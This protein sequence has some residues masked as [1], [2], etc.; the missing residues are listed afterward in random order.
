MFEDAFELLLTGTPFLFGEMEVA[1]ER[2]GVRVVLIDL[3]RFFEPIGSFVDLTPVTRHATQ[4]EVTVDVV[5][6]LAEDALRMRC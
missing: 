5:A 3:Q 4:A 2:P 6:V 1:D